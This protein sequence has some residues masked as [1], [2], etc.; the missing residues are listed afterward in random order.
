M[1]LP[2]HWVVLDFSGKCRNQFF[3]LQNIFNDRLRTKN[4]STL[5]HSLKLLTNAKI[6]IFCYIPHQNKRNVY[7]V[8]H[9][10]EKNLRELPNFN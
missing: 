10:E 5:V 7:F 8:T 3:L 2:L 6:H 4:Y 9:G 1:L